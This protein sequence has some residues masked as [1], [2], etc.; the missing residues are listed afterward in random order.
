M[1]TEI[2]LAIG[3]ILT[4]QKITIG[5][6]LSSQIKPL[7]I[8]TNVRKSFFGGS[9]VLQVHNTSD[10]EITLWL[11]AKEKTESYMLQTG[12]SKD[13]GW[14]QGFRFEANDA[15]F[16]WAD[17]CDTIRQ[18]MPSDELS[19]WRLQFTERG[20]FVLNL[21]QSYVQNRLQEEVKIPFEQ[22]YS[23]NLCV[24]IENY[25][26]VIFRDGSNRIFAEVPITT[27]WFRTSPKVLIKTTI[28]FVPI[29]EPSSGKVFATD[30]QI[31]N[32][33]IN[34]VPKEWLSNFKDIINQ[35][36]VVLFKPFVIFQLDKSILKYAKFFKVR[37]MIVHDGRLEIH[38]L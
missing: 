34:L 10:N 38:F 17:R 2:V 20:G 37:E 9:Y 31:N 26:Q 32:I 36:L 4:S 28:S 29:Y 21:S 14:A 27:K 35:L 15:Y 19:Q 22:S 23:N 3:L 18:M 24:A 13:I 30:L 7:P 1:V 12:E 33:D 25:P 6:D 8:K 16:L 11:G 5:D